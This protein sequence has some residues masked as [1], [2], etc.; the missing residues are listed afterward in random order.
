[1]KKHA[2]KLFCFQNFYMRR[3]IA[4]A[5]DETDFRVKKRS[6]FDFEVIHPQQS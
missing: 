6:W 1:M 5:H 2:T 3:L 4:P